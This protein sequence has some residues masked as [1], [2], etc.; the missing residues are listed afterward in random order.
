[1][2]RPVEKSV[3]EL[4]LVCRGERWL[5]EIQDPSRSRPCP[6]CQGEGW[7]LISPASL[8][9]DVPATEAPENE[10]PKPQSEG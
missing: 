3:R 9:E 6:H 5:P 7:V 4:C 1:M 2:S 8:G 10:A